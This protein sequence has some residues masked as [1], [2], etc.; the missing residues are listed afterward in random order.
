MKKKE[1]KRRKIELMTYEGKQC[2]IDEFF[3]IKKVKIKKK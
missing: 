2:T 3:E 1:K